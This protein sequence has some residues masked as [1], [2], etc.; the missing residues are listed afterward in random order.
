MEDAALEV[1]EGLKG[2]PFVFNLAHGIN[3]ET[4]P[5]HVERLAE[6]IH[7]WRASA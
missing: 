7:N 4:P 6:I 3:K 1:L 5:A 2:G